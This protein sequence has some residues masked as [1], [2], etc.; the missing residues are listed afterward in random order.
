[1]RKLIRKNAEDKKRSGEGRISGHREGFHPLIL[2]GFAAV[3]LLTLIICVCIGSV[4]VPFADTVLVLW[5][6]ITRQPVPGDITAGSI[7]LSVSLGAVLAI[8][9]NII[10]PHSPFSGTM[11]MA[12]G[13]AFLSFMVIMALAYRLD[14]SLSTNTI[15]LI[16]II[17]SMFVNSIM[18]LVVTFAHDKVKSITFWTMGSLAGSSYRSAA[19]LG[20]VLAAGYVILFRFAQELNA[21]A[22]GEDNAR[23]V[24]VN[25]RRVRIIVLITVSALIGVCVSIGGTIGFVGLVTPHIVRMIT[26]PNHRRL[27]PAVMFGGAV[28]LML[29][30]LTAR[31]ILR[32]LELPIGVV[33][34]FIGA[35]LFVYIFYKTRT[36][37]GGR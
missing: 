18:S 24:G 36:S 15:V 14:Y 25:V 37:R 29:A 33:T 4:N 19:V 10:L 35:V 26:G 8:A 31:V 34:S 11:V 12:I 7:I 21:F 27:L 32:P 2:L 20:A 17:Y 13:F 30:D 9:F 28:F 6:G 16:G 22:I 1:M 5:K 3:T 23:H